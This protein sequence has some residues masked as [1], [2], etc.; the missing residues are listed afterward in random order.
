[1]SKQLWL[2]DVFCSSVAVIERPSKGSRKMCFCLPALSQLHDGAAG[3]SGLG[4]LHHLWFGHSVLRPCVGA[5]EYSSCGALVWAQLYSSTSDLVLIVV[6]SLQL[7]VFIADF[8][9]PSRR[10]SSSDYYQSEFSYR[11]IINTV[12]RNVYF[13]NVNTDLPLVRFC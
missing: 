8:A 6:L 4:V 10:F 9:F 5:G 3:D 1:M 13:I 12:L 11:S 7:L 2:F